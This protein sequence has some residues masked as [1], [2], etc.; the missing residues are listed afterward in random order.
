MGRRKGATRKAGSA[1]E[2]ENTEPEQPSAV[3]S[4]VKSASQGNS[5]QPKYNLNEEQKSQKRKEMLAQLEKEG[6]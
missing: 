1:A 4:P 2:L 5:S 3:A 6:A